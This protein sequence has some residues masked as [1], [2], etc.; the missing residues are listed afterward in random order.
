MKRGYSSKGIVEF[1][2]PDG[3]CCITEEKKKAELDV[4]FNTQ[5]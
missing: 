5:T 4:F 1:K 2:S 3:N